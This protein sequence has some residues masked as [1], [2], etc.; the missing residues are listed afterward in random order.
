MNSTQRH[1]RRYQRR[2]ARREQRKKERAEKV[3]GLS[4][5]FT[6][7]RLYKMG[8]VC[9]NGVRWKNSTQRFEAHIFS[10]TAVTRR[11]LLAHTWTP[12]P[13]CTFRLVERGKE[14]IIDAPTIRDR[15]VHKALTRSALVPLYLPDIIYNNGASLPGKG[16]HFACKILKRDLR[17]HFRR[18]GREGSIILMDFKQFFPSAPHE[19]IYE[20]HRRLLLNDEIRAV[21]DKVV[22]STGKDRGLP[23][24]VEVSQIEMVGLPSPLD[25]YIKCQLGIHCMGHYMDDYYIIVPPDRDARE[26]LAKI[27]TKA[28]EI[29]FTVSL[30]KTKIHPLARPF[31]YCKAKYTL[32]ETG[33]VIV[34]GNR[35]SVKRARRKIRAFKGMVDRGQMDGES[36]RE[37]VQ[38]TLAYFENYNDHNRILRLRRLFFSLFGYSPESK[39]N[40]RGGTK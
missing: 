21:A 18:Y 17:R 27:V 36:L 26:I 5:L 25:N 30:S 24:G 9:C 38:S 2:K 1:E 35:D 37:S 4:E 13:Y 8:K 16:F 22:A 15:Q 7:K 34:N 23:L 40:F 3:G 10:A 28:R 33:K 31:R 11:A 6:F 14:R 20:R 32:T 12:S 19:A 29:G 39:W